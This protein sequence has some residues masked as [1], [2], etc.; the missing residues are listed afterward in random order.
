MPIPFPISR[1]YYSGATYDGESFFASKCLQKGFKSVLPPKV[2]VFYHIGTSTLAWKQIVS[3]Q[4]SILHSCGWD[5]ELGEQAERNPLAEVFPDCDDE[6]SW[7][8]YR[9]D[10]VGIEAVAHYFVS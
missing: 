10:P 9:Y 2:K 1:H 4:L 5:E 3:Q 8:V 7:F 6:R